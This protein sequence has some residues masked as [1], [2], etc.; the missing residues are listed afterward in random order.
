MFLGIKSG[1]MVGSMFGGVLF[2]CLRRHYITPTAIRK[3]ARIFAGAY[4]GVQIQMTLIT[5]VR[6]F[7][8]PV[9]IMACAV[10]CLLLFLPRV[11]YRLTG[12]SLDTCLLS[13]S[14]GG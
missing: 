6:N 9:L 4:I 10:A 12:L 7:L 5:S 14:R 11:M 13:A 1:M 8:V 2:G 3:G